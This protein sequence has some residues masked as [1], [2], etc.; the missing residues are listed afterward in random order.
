MSLEEVGRQS[1]FW[2]WGGVGKLVG[3]EFSRSGGAGLSP[4]LMQSEDLQPS[5]LCNYHCCFL[6]PSFPKLG[7]FPF[8]LRQCFLHSSST[9]PL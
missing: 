6:S 2:G 1:E 4:L 5:K 9:R 3:K 8:I 7:S